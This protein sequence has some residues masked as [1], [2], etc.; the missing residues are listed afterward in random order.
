MR[1]DDEEF[2]GSKIHAQCHY[3]KKMMRLE[4]I[5]FPALVNG[6]AQHQR[7]RQIVCCVILESPG[8]SAIDTLFTL[9]D[10]TKKIVRCDDDFVDKPW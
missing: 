5:S 6:I 4:E 1:C 9:T 8:P 7:T 2:M 3:S 10:R